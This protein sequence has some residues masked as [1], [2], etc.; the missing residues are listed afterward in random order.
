M[1]EILNGDLVFE[2]IKANI[3]VRLVSFVEDGKERI[4]P[5]TGYLISISIDK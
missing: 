4:N 2:Y 5:R 3:L 1:K